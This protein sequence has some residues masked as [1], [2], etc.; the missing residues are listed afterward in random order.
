M[1]C[2]K[3]NP[4]NKVRLQK[5]LAA[6]GVG[7]RRHCES[8]IAEGRVAVDG[9][10]VTEQGI[11]VDPDTQRLSVDGRDV[12][13][14][15]PLYLA[16]HKPR[17]IVCTLKDTHGRK[18]VGDLLPEYGE[19]LFHVGRLDAD[20]E[21]LLL[22]TNDGDWAEQILHPRHRVD[23]VYRVTLDRAV[24]ASVLKRWRQG[25]E[26]DGERLTMASVQLHDPESAM[27][28]IILHEGRK[29]QIRRMARSA[30]RKVLRLVR[31]RIGS[32]SLEDLPPGASRPLTPAER[33]ALKG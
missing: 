31:I 22:M 20:S 12:D 30:G 16:L 14:E 3:P 1:A 25:I 4:K 6:C 23:K 29:R 19:R 17:G 24:D 10:V 32:V 13:P 8:L 28:E 18:T 5:A 27:Y 9:A 33:H 21:G 7:S 15:T 26:D 2:G 11:Q